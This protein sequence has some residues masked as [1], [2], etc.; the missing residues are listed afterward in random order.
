MQTFSRKS[1]PT[2]LLLAVATNIE[3]KQ[4]KI[5]SLKRLVSLKLVCGYEVNFLDLTNGESY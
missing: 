1:G 5:F 4:S 2:W 3:S